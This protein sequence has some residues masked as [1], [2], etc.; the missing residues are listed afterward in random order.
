MVASQIRPADVTDR[1]LQDAML[2][3]PR[4][5]FLP[6]S[7]AGSAYADMEIDLGEGRRFMR[8]RDFAKLVQALGVKPG[9]LV[10]DLAC[11]RGYSTAILSR[12]CETVIGIE[13]NESFASKAEGAL[14]DIGAD[15]A[16]IVTADIK[17]GA[18]EQGPFDVILVNGAVELVPDAWLSQLAENG[19]LGVI[20]KENGVGRARVYT[21][22]N[23]VVGSRVVFDSM[24][25]LLPGFEREP[26]FLL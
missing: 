3:I 5:R 9:E 2:A 16:V 11:A 13:A 7:M 21:R 6:R 22:R 12:L 14:S 18:P 15:N 25:S 20:V 10:L 8:P 23:G 17:K 26:E 24:T 19:R 1:R 4:E